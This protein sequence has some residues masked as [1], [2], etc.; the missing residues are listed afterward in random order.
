MPSGKHQV[1]IHVPIDHI[2]NFI[3]DIDN[4]APLVP[5]YITHSRINE[6]QSTWDFQNENGL[7]KK[8]ISL[9]ID[10]QEWTE[11]TLVSFQLSSEKYN[12]RGYFQAERLTPNKTNVTGYLEIEA[13]GTM[14]SMKNKILNSVLPKKTE[15]LA[16][17]ILEILEKR[18]IY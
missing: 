16:L 6:R 13:E 2:W 17:A 14:S 8:N 1:E 5:G 4:W 3:K 11:P 9:L 15:E 7:I 18:V 10:I 12:G